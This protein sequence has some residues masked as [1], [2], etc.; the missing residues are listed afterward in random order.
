MC[1]EV[2]GGITPGCLDC[3]ALLAQPGHDTLSSR[4]ARTGTEAVALLLH[5][6]HRWSN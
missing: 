1:A 2:A 3:T 5:V 6:L 4:T